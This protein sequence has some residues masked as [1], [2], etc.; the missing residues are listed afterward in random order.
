M[1]LRMIMI[2]MFAFHIAIPL[3]ALEYD[4]FF[5]ESMGLGGAY[6]A[7]LDS[8]VSVFYNPAS[9]YFYND[10]VKPVYYLSFG[11]GKRGYEN[12]DFLNYAEQLAD[13]IGKPYG[14]WD[15]M[16]LDELIGGFQG[17]SDSDPSLNGGTGY[18][19]LVCRDGFAVYYIEQEYSDTVFEID[20]EKINYTSQDDPD[21][22]LNNT[23]ML[24]FYGIKISQ[25]C[26]SYSNALDNDLF[27]G[28]TFKFITADSY[29][30]TMGLFEMNGLK[31]RDTEYYIDSSFAGNQESSNDYTFDIGMLMKLGQWGLLG[32]TA[33]NIKK[34]ELEGAFE[35]IKISPQYRVGFTLFL[36]PS[37]FI[38]IDRD[39]TEN[40][41]LSSEIKSQK[42]SIGIQ[43]S[44]FED[45]FVLRAG[46][47]K[48]D[49]SRE[50][51]WRYYFGAGLRIAD[52]LDFQGSYHYASSDDSFDY[53]WG[54]NL[55][56]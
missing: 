41:T 9:L 2:V 17:I 33:K 32:F 24:E 51:A 22:I 20:M 10:A 31:G 12:H 21:S 16:D 7:V 56:L 37:A 34:V 26:I 6:T 53:Q 36:S 30:D 52:Y 49:K 27:I 18:S 44:F 11:Y 47:R 39:L 38:T 25:Y 35:E 55:I 4:D 46:A 15:D 45:S 23:S 40:D 19:F 13:V 48:D 14:E 1:K 8:P 5:P 28:T 29:Y 54:L 42:L 3:C 50:S 43:K